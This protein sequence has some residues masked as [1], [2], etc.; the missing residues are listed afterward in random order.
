MDTLQSRLNK[1]LPGF[2]PRWSTYQDQ[3][4]VVVPSEQI[5]VTLKACK[6]I[7]FDQLTDLT[8]VDLLEYGGS[9]DRFEVVYLLLNTETGERLTVKIYLNEPDL[10]IPPQRPFGPV[11]IG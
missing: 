7:G 1:E 6:K 10:T 8:C 5:L 4:R 9:E 2:F 11:Q 3:T